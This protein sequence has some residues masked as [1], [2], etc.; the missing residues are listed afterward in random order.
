[1]DEAINI[2]R[3]G[4]KLEKNGLQSYLEFAFNTKDV[5]GKNMFIKLSRDELTH[6]DTLEKQ[7]DNLACGKVWK[8][9]EIP[10]SIIEK[11]TPQLRKSDKQKSDKGADELG[12]LKTA[13]TLE[14]E[15]IDF[16]NSA[17]TKISN[18]DAI[19]M[20]DRIIEMEESHYD[21][22]QAEIDHIESTGFWFGIPEFSLESEPG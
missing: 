15:S 16:Y 3:T 2:L 4:I 18:S 20:F 1:M 11:L 10:H 5:T 13:L 8:C 17:K 9:E 14:K 7:L 12:A 21:L 19:K 22:I 6:M